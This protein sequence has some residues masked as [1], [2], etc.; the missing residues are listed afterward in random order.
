MSNIDPPTWIE[1]V[2]FVCIIICFVTTCFQMVVHIK[3]FSNP[4]YQK[5][6]L[7]LLLMAPIYILFSSLTIW[8]NDADGCF[9]LIR[10]IYESFVIYAFFKLL[11]AYVGY[12]PDKPTIED[13]QNKIIGILSEKGPHAHQW[14]FNYCLAPMNLVNMEEARKYYLICKY[15]ILQYIPIKIILA[16]LEFFVVYEEGEESIYY[17][18]LSGIEFFAVCLALYWLVFF[19]HIFY[20]DLEPF[21]PLMKF[22]I[23]KGILF[24]TFWQELVLSYCGVYLSSSR[25]I[26]PQNRSDAN[27]ILSCML[28]NIEMVI[29]S[30][31]TTFAFSYK[32]FVIGKEKKKMNLK[33]FIQVKMFAMKMKNF[34]AK[35]K[36]EKG[37]EMNVVEMQE[38]NEIEDKNERINEKIHTRAMGDNI[39]G[40]S[41]G[42]IP[43]IELNT[44][45]NLMEDDKK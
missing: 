31:L 43:L 41:Q 40:M 21:K 32:D 4:A 11:G 28:V 26:P 9:L 10:N 20:E 25:Y 2:T 36:K 8:I 14:P 5:N 22:L 34:A 37:N 45:G 7:A 13:I 30:I 15:G 33:D 42:E 18:L 39:G 16:S 35:K 1:D 29:M 6:I 12:E 3:N 38:F 27:I 44:V 19:F 23:I 17:K 24:V